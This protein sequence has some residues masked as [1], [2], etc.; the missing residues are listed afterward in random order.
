[1]FNFFF[2]GDKPNLKQYAV[3]L[4]ERIHA[5][6]PSQGLS[7]D[8]ARAALVDPDGQV[9]LNLGNLHSDY[10]R[11]TQ[12]QRA[13]LLDSQAQV[14]CMRSSP[15]VSGDYE[16]T[17]RRN[18]VPI[19]RNRLNAEA[20]LRLM[21]PSPS[22]ADCI[23][24]R[25]LNEDLV[26]HIAFD[27]EHTIS[28]VT[29]SMLAHW[30][31]GFDDALSDAF[32]NLRAM[33]G[34]CWEAMEGG[35][36]R[37]AW[38][39]SYDCSRLL[40]PEMFAELPLRGRPVAI[41]P[42][43]G[44]IVAASDRDLPAQLAMLRHARA[45]LE[46]NTRWA[47]GSMLVLEGDAWTTYE[48]GD[49]AVRRARDS[50]RNIV[51]HSDYKNQ[52]TALE[53]QHEDELIAIFV[54]SFMVYENDDGSGEMRSYCTYGEGVEAYLPK[55]DRVIFLR[56]G[57]DGRPDASRKIIVPWDEARAI[58]GPLM[59]PVDIYPPRFHVQAFPDEATLTRLRA[60]AVSL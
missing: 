21:K 20:A 5:V 44:E 8:E 26:V 9:R 52:K 47:A 42:A 54:A 13:A 31:V 60:A 49:D 14:A 39:D 36:F 7:F 28:Q 6:D 50:L 55:A 56:L 32:A 18:L 51:L 58:T 23:P 33:G 27:T 30:G 38:Q 12:E 11:A 19:V 48:P 43:R 57:P 46:D 10:L 17:A 35:F 3:R 53:Q 40:L 41:V 25:P 37:G 34:P 1:M 45:S 29:E 2:R 4:L 15:D 59:A 22:K 16:T 24:G